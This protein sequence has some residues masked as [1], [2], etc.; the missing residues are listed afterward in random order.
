MFNNVNPFTQDY[1]I[2]FLKYIFSRRSVEKVLS[3]VAVVTVKVTS[4]WRS[5][6]TIGNVFSS[7][8]HNAEWEFII[9][10]SILIIYSNQSLTFPNVSWNPQLIIVSYLS[11]LTFYVCLKHENMFCVY[12]VEY[13]NIELPYLLDEVFI[14][15]SQ[16]LHIFWISLKI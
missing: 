7:H 12:L 15:I 14:L 9:I 6:I 13:N 8:R 1:S 16:P 3:V 5:F 2:V 10:L 11:S 4:I